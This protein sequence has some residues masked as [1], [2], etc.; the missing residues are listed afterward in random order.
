MKRGKKR[1]THAGIFI[2]AVAAIVASVAYVSEIDAEI[3]VALESRLWTVSSSWIPRWAPDFV[4]HVSAVARA[5]AP[6]I[7]RDAVA[8]GALER[9]RLAHELLAAILVAV[10]S[11]IVLGVASPP[12]GDA[13][14]VVALELRLRTL[15]VTILAH[16]LCLVAT[17]TAVVREVAQPLLRHAT[18]VRTLEVHL[19]VAF[20]AVLG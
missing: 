3:V 12:R 11:A 20:R 5:V 16:G 1:T 17:V 19:R 2:R 15:S 14:A 8:A 9:V 13:L 18:V 6:Q 4:A 7:R 10:V